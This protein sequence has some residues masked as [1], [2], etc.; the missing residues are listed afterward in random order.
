MATTQRD[1]A[2]ALQPDVTLWQLGQ[3]I[4]EFS[5]SDHDWV[6]DVEPG[7]QLWRLGSQVAVF[8][9]LQVRRVERCVMCD[10]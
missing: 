2:H 4:A 8:P 5:D 9:T 10:V 1:L 6:D 3:K 7:V